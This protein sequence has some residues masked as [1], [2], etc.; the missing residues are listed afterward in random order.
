MRGIDWE[1]AIGIAMPLGFDTAIVIEHVDVSENE[2]HVKINAAPSRR[3]AG[4]RAVGSRFKTGDALAY[5]GEII[6]PDVAAR[7]ASGN[8]SAVQVVWKP[9]VAVI[10]AGNEVVCPGGIARLRYA[11]Y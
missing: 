6:T 7:I 10:R 5:S 8:V 11:G 9:G 4:T 2:Q 3:F 1:F